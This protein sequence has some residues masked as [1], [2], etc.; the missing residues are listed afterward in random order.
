MSRPS[1]HPLSI[2][3]IDCA[4]DD[5]EQLFTR[6]REK[7]S[8]RGDVVSESGRQ[9]TIELFGKPLSPH[10]VVEVICGD[11]RREGLAA[12]LGYTRKLDGQELTAETMRISPAELEEAHYGH[13]AIETIS[14]SSS[15]QLTVAFGAITRKQ[16]QSLTDV[17]KAFHIHFDK[18]HLDAEVMGH[19]LSLIADFNISSP[20]GILNIKPQGSV[21]AFDR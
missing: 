8:P 21:F 1:N 10:E 3:T 19:L 7:L 9:R 2:T 16:L 13:R 20:Y 5:A 11:V 4:R 17:F 15:K 12:V 6:L 14:T 18:V